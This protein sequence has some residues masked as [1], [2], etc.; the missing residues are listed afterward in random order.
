[1]HEATLSETKISQHLVVRHSLPEKVEYDIGIMLLRIDRLVKDFL[2]GRLCSK[3]ITSWGWQFHPIIYINFF[4]S[5]VVGNGISEP[6]TV[7]LEH[8]FEIRKNLCT[9]DKLQKLWISKY[10]PAWKNPSPRGNFPFEMAN[11]DPQKSGF[12][13]SRKLLEF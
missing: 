6:S 11:F 3:G 8:T 1:M 4:A 2:L 10:G 13:V 5:Q 7:C 12:F 9:T